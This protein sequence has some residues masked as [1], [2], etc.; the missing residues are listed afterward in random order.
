[1]RTSALAFMLVGATSTASSQAPSQD[2]ALVRYA[3]ELQRADRLLPTNRR[4]YF[5]T[6]SRLTAWAAALAAV[7]PPPTMSAA[8]KRL[9][10]YSREYARHQPQAA[11]A[12]T[13]GID[14]CTGR[15]T[16]DQTCGAPSPTADDRAHF[17]RAS[18]A[19][20]QYEVVR[21]EIARALQVAGLTPPIAW[22][23]PVLN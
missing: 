11:V 22:L 14:A 12:P 15:A 2:S 16:P 18:H 8:H 6:G 13:A 20:G 3:T 5:E 4:D 21:R 23:S 7:V 9:L 10:G 19:L 17:D 1:M